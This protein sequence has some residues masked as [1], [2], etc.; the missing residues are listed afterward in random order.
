AG[1]PRDRALQGV[2]GADGRRGARARPQQRPRHRQGRGDLLR[3]E[4]PALAVPAVLEAR[5]DQHAGRGALL[6]RGLAQP[7]RGRKRH[8][9]LDPGDLEGRA[10]PAL[11]RA[12]RERELERHDDVQAVPRL[13]AHGVGPRLREGHPEGDG[14]KVVS[15]AS[16]TKKSAVQ[17]AEPSGHANGAASGAATRGTA[18][19]TLRVG[20]IGVGYWGPNVIRNLV[21]L[22]RCRL[23]V[24]CDSDPARLAPLERLYP[25]LRREQDWRALLA[26]PALDA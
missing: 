4:H 23:E 5:D 2:L 24:V 11:P 10:L 20:V 8:G 9:L 16:R 13:A 1:A 14:L 6:C 22:E 7:W 17:P 15:E 26:D 19:K 12:A 25:G 21:A 18:A 3:R